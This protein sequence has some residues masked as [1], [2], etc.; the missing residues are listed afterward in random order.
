[1]SGEEGFEFRQQLACIFYAC[2]ARVG[3]KAFQFWCFLDFFSVTVSLNYLPCRFIASFSTFKELYVRV[4]VPFRPIL[5]ASFSFPLTSSPPDYLSLVVSPAVNPV[6]V[7]SFRLDLRARKKSACK[8]CNKRTNT[9]K[10]MYCTRKRSGQVED[11]RKVPWTCTTKH[12]MNNVLS[13]AKEPFL[14]W[15]R[16]ERHLT[17]LS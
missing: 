1:M 3:K 7:M 10:Y 13:S 8:H 12:I 2:R 6:A 11:K 17:L 15:I 9:A 14:I 4:C 16:W 5:Y